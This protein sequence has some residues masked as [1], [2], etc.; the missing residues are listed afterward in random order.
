MDKYRQA[1]LAIVIGGGVV[2]PL[3]L[4][5]GAGIGAVALHAESVRRAE[6]YALMQKARNE[7]GMLKQQAAKLVQATAVRGLLGSLTV[8]KDLPV[9]LERTR[10]VQGAGTI[11]TRIS[12]EAATGLRLLKGM[13]NDRATV[14]ISGRWQS[15]GA[16][17]CAWEKSFPWLFLASMEAGPATS[18]SPSPETR[19]LAVR[20][21]YLAMAP[22]PPNEIG[23]KP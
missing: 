19:P 9:L 5:L 23:G 14:D 15:I 2:F 4:L 20:C 11:D 3:A 13:G 8:R 10:A 21:G 7:E 22:M 18:Q 1:F 6:D 16:A 17:V 12:F